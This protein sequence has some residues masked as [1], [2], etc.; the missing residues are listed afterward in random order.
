MGPL[1]AEILGQQFSNYR[2]GD[3]FWYETNESPQAFTVGKHTHFQHSV[4]KLVTC[5][6]L[7]RNNSKIKRQNRNKSLNTE[8]HD[9]QSETLYFWH[10]YYFSDINRF[11]NT[12]EFI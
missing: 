3:R 1:F 8:S 12:F 2:K 11:P 5:T 4:L 6:V 7:L 10:D 9:Q